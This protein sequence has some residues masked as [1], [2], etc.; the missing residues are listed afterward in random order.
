MG[1]VWASPRCFAVRPLHSGVPR[2][3]GA[4]AESADW[5][6]IETYNFSTPKHTGHGKRKA[7]ARSTGAER[8]PDAPFNPHQW[9]V[10]IIGTV[11]WSQGQDSLSV[12]CCVVICAMRNCC[13]CSCCHR[14][15][16][17][18]R[19]TERGQ[20]HT[21][22]SLGGRALLLSRQNSGQA[23]CPTSSSA[24]RAPAPLP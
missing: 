24:N 8:D 13:V 16:A 19:A 14:W 21:V 9:H 1:R 2:R 20:E 5:T 22:Q 18:Q 7:K 15:R 10:A 12:M 23:P 11:L 17:F 4:V 6:D 3:S